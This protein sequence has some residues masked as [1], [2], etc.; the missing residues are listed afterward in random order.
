MTVIVTMTFEFDT[1][2]DYKD[3]RDTI[4]NETNYASVVVDAYEQMEEE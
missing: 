3:F 4:Y 2:Q 1:V